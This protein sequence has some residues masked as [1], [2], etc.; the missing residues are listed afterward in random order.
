MEVDEGVTITV[1]VGPRRHCDFLT[2]ARDD[3]FAVWFSVNQGPGSLATYARAKTLEE[4]AAMSPQTFS[5]LI[6]GGTLAV[7]LALLAL[8]HWNV[9]ANRSVYAS[10]VL[11]LTTISAALLLDRPPRS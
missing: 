1:V 9:V 6:P 11:L 7:I 4:D 10:A 8:H 5:R 3:S 2:F